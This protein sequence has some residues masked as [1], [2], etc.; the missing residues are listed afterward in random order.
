MGIGLWF[1]LVPIAWVRNI[2]SFSFSF[3]VGNL[4]IITTVIV[5]IFYLSYDFNRD[6]FGPGIIPWNHDKYWSM[7]GFSCYTYEGIGVVMPIMSNCACPEKFD[8]ILFY[9]LMTLTF[10]YIVFAD[11]CYLVLGTNIDRTFIT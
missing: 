2:S 3:L 9:A 5:V 8:K 4:C 7:V 10:I 11:F 6:G 1:I